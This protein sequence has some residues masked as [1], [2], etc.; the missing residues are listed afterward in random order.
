MGDN[1]IQYEKTLASYEALPHAKPSLS[2]NKGMV[3]V[4]AILY[5]EYRIK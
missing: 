4:N 3:K 1:Y 5:V 2:I